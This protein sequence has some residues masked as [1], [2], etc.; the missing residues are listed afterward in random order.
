MLALKSAKLWR[1]QHAGLLSTAA[2]IIAAS[3]RHCL[4][5]GVN[6]MTGCNRAQPLA[7][8][9]Y[10][11]QAAPQLEQTELRHAARKL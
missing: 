4:H 8:Q 10:L 3:H 2:C 11:M 7:C 1:P 5:P 6:R 9:S